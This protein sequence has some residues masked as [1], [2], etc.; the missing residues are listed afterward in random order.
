MAT[1]DLPVVSYINDVIVVDVALLVRVLEDSLGI[2]EQQR[3]YAAVGV[4]DV[5]LDSNN[6]CFVVFACEALENIVLIPIL[7]P[8]LDIVRAE[9]VHASTS[10][11]I[12]VKR[13]EFLVTA[14]A[15]ASLEPAVRLA[16]IWIQGLPDRKL[17]VNVAG[18][19]FQYPVTAS[20]IESDPPMMEPEDWVKCCNRYVPHMPD[21]AVHINT[22]M[23]F[24][25]C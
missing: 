19:C 24:C 7:F 12:V 14:G 13:N 21:T 11:E 16:S 6:V 22:P 5:L 9:V 25:G 18:T 17:T 10:T 23:K 20:R 15:V 4:V 3:S 8:D 1:A 2:V